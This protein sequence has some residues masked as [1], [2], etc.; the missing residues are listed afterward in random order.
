MNITPIV[1]ESMAITKRAV[2]AALRSCS[3]P[4]GPSPLDADNFLLQQA[5]VFY[6]CSLASR[7]MYADS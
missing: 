6:P 4:I 1:V 7:L 5:K 2:L 3:S